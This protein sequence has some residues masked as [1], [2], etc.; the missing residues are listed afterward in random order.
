MQSLKYDVIQHKIN[1]KESNLSI[2][3]C[4][5]D[6]ERVHLLT[7]A[8]TQAGLIV[9]FLVEPEC[10]S[11]CQDD[12][13]LTFG[14]VST[15]NGQACLCRSSNVICPDLVP[16]VLSGG[17]LIFLAAAQQEDSGT[18]GW[19]NVSFLFLFW[20]S[21]VISQMIWITIWILGNEQRVQKDC[22]SPGD[23]P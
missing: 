10:W 18:I 22:C 23:P 16:G 8:G 4:E 21:T 17:Y 6:V 19:W 1:P 11:H 15:N 5:W 2:Y 3:R 20:L 9:H 14:C 13:A 12:C 7:K